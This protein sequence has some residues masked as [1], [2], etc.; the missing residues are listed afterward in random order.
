MGSSVTKSGLTPEEQV[1]QLRT[2]PN[3]PGAEDVEAM[4]NRVLALETLYHLAGRS[5]ATTG[6]KCT[7]T[8]LWQPAPDSL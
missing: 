7:Y 5:Q 3:K 1:K 4:N 2:T 8:A 6:L